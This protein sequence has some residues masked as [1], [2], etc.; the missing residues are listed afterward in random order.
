MR[1]PGMTLNCLLLSV[2]CLVSPVSADTSRER[3]A[4]FLSGQ[5]CP[6]SHRILVAELAQV[7]GVTR[8]DLESVPDHALVDV[9]SGAVT[10]EDLL[11]AA[12]R[13]AL[14]GVR[15]QAEIMKSCISARSSPAE[16]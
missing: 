10:P 5:D 15:C 6:S 3:V 8:V 16:R 11:A 1:C 12:R 2:G 9:L 13:H 7:A 4:L 14:N